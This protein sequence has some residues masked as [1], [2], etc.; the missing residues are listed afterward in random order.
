MAVRL[1][2]PPQTGNPLLDQWAREMKRTL[3]IEI[4][5]LQAQAIL[6]V[7]GTGNLPS[8]KPPPR[9]IAVQTNTADPPIPAISDGTAWRHFGT[10]TAI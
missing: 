5:R 7:Y 2:D 8:A 10:G 1:P 6:P 3:E 9:W 4:T